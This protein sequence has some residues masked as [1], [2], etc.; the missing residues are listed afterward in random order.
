VA[1]LLVARDTLKQ[2]LEAQRDVLKS[3]VERRR[4]VNMRLQQGTTSQLE[5]LDVERDAWQAEQAVVQINRQLLAT[6]AQ[7]FKAFGGGDL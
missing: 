1:D 5:W 6:T 2:Q 7:L 4:L 3:Q